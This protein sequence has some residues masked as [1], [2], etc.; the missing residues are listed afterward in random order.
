MVAEV[1]A[2]ADMEEV[3]S[4]KDPRIRLCEPPATLAARAAETEVGRTLAGNNGDMAVDVH[5]DVV[6]RRY[7]EEVEG[8]CECDVEV[9]KVSVPSLANQK[10][11]P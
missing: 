11:E 7:Q 8:Y 5:Y 10:R 2:E 6:V 4:D 3:K 9:G 1:V